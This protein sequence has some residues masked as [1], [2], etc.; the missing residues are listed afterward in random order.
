M[1][2]LSAQAQRISDIHQGKVDVA[3]YPG[4][5]NLDEY[6]GSLRV[7]MLE[8]VRHQQIIDRFSWDHEEADQ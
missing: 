2:R 1:P 5:T 4:I 8:N 3:H 6:A 7:K